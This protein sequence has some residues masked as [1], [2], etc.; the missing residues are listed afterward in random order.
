MVTRFAIGVAVSVFGLVVGIS[1]QPVEMSAPELDSL[2][3]GGTCCLTEQNLGHCNNNMSCNIRWK[4]EAQW[5]VGRHCVED[6]PCTLSVDCIEPAPGT[7][8]RCGSLPCSS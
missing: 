7:Y 3:G 5:D 4:C 1:L 6:N 2:V 8:D